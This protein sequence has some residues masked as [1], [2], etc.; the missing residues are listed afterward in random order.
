[1][2]ICVDYTV[3]I[4]ICISFNNG[5][6]NIIQYGTEWQ[7][8]Y[9]MIQKGLGWQQSWLHLRYCFSICVKRLERKPWRMWG[10]PVSQ[11]IHET[12]T[13]HIQFRSVI[14]SANMLSQYDLQEWIICDRCLYTTGNIGGCEVVIVWFSMCQKYHWNSVTQNW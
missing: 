1:M 8:D 11:Q 12:V 7:N 6:S 13:S 4:I 2:K 5:V 3:N 10:W 9:C 14:T